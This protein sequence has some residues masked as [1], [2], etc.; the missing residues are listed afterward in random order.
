MLSLDNTYSVEEL[1]EFYAR[2][3]RLL[4]GKN[5]SGGRAQGRWRRGF[6]PVRKRRNTLRSHSR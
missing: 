5:S 4:P 1:T 2:I 6:G 3:T